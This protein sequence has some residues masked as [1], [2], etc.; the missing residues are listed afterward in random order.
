M[1]SKTL[2]I[3]AT[4]FHVS[5]MNTNEIREEALR[6]EKEDWKS[7]NH[8]RSFIQ[9]G[10]TILGVFLC[11]LMTVPFLS[12]LAWALALAV[13]FMPIHR[14]ILKK[15]KKKNIAA[16]L[17]S[18]LAIII[19]VIPVMWMV[20]RVVLEVDRGAT[21]IMDRVSSGEWQ[22]NLESMPF[23]G[24]AVYWLENHLNIHQ[25]VNNLTSWLTAQV[26]LFLRSSFIQIIVIVLTFYLLFYFLR[27]RNEILRTVRRFSP[28]CGRETNGLF[29]VV[30]DTIRATV[31]GTLAVS[32]VKG[33]LSGFMFWV[34]GLPA[35]LLW[36]SIM[37]ILSI[38]PL[39]GSY[40]IWIPAAVYLALDGYWAQALVL[41][42]WGIVVGGVVNNVLYPILVSKK[43]KLHTIVAFIALAGGILVYGASGVILGPI[44]LTAS[45]F[46]L[47]L[48]RLKATGY[49]RDITL[50]T[51]F[52]DS[53]ES[54]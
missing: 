10:I 4:F 34:L 36:G 32:A 12:S 22:D 41:V 2:R 40:I 42:I 8:I 27:D 7:R 24:R 43:L 35:P 5:A 17:T 49:K 20:I 14:R 18:A 47:H 38:I 16:M 31:F 54:L 9:L 25:A 45:A 46:L 48:W 13:L 39:L 1:T 53:A 26:T 29:K 51:A 11:Y 30:N 28:L 52:D 6:P 3:T 19:V 33:F 50:P 44:T 15:L 37:G 23:V 21:L